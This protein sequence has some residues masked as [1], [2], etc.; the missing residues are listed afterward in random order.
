MTV[1]AYLHGKRAEDSRSLIVIRAAIFRNLLQDKNILNLCNMSVIK[2]R[3]LL[4]EISENLDEQNVR[5]RL[6][7]MCKGGLVS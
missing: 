2:Y 3:N 6:L 7:F 5:S 4:F 1:T